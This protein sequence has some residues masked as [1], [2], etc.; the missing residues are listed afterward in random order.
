MKPQDWIKVTDKL[1]EEGSAVVIC[2]KKMH[3]AYLVKYIDGFKIDGKIIP[4]DEVLC[5]VEI[6]PPPSEFDK[7]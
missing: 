5:W 3:V 4:N 1:P 2:L 7:Q 6:V